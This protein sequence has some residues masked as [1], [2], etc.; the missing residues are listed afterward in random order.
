MFIGVPNP[1]VG[2][3]AVDELD[4][5]DGVG[6]VAPTLGEVGLISEL[7]GRVDLY[8]VVTAVVS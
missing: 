8:H 6:K 4:E 2:L 3:S 5:T 1:Q 7:K